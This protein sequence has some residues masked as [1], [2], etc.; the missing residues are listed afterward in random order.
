MN[1]YLR[2][3]TDEKYIA[4]TSYLDSKFHLRLNAEDLKCE[5]V[6]SITGL[7]VVKF[8]QLSM[9]CPNTNWNV[10]NSVSNHLVENGYKNLIEVGS[11]SLHTVYSAFQTVQQKQ[12]GS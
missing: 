11:C 8:I 1:V 2:H 6:A 10:L 5:L 3:W 4:G 7:D 9:D 12:T